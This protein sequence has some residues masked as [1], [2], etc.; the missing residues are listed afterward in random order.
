MKWDILILNKTQELTQFV[1]G[2][3][4]SVDFSEPSPDLRRN[5]NRELHGTVL[6]LSSRDAHGIEKSILQSLRNHV[7]KSKPES[8]KMPLQT[9]TI[10][11]A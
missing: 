5:N 8:T 6:S 2:R 11:L 1:L 4:E 10:H 3:S 7:R 9:S